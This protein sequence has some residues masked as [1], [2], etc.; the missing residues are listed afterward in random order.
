MKLVVDI[1]NTNVVTAVKEQDKWSYI[2]RFETLKSASEFDYSVKINNLLWEAGIDTDKLESVVLSTVVPELKDKFIS[3]LTKINKDKFI[4]LD[5][6]IYPFL[7]IRI[8]N[9]DEIGTDLVAN[10]LAAFN[11]Y[12]ENLIIIDFG[13]AL[14]FTVINQK[15]EILG[16]NIAPGIKTAI[17][18][19]SDKTSQLDWVPLRLP[20]SPLGFNTETAI[21]NGVLLGYTGLIKY[22]IASLKNEVGEKYKVLATGGLSDVLKE[23]LP[24]IDYFD[25]QLTLD[26]LALVDRFIAK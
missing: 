9:P 7:N 15:G 4:L 6:K 8:P 3:L 11:K 13:T 20:E 25:R 2:W 23:K 19:L 26:G 17:R 16:V 22:M 1:G 18:S 14:T 12:K 5:K 21:Q 24:E 10:S